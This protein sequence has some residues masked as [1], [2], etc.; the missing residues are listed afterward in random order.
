MLGTYFQFDSSF[1]QYLEV[2]ISLGSE[3]FWGQSILRPQRCLGRQRICGRQSPEFAKGKQYNFQFCFYSF[4]RASTS[5][6]QHGD[7]G[8][9]F[10]ICFYY[11][12]GLLGSGNRG[13]LA[14]EYYLFLLYYGTSGKWQQG[15]FGNRLLPVSIISHAR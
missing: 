9:G 4:I 13:I 7:F 11:I 14:T 5:K 3:G 8:N 12:L 2:K 15:I 1:L 10:I 6:W